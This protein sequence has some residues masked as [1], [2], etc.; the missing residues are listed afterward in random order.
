M[1]GQVDYGGTLRFAWTR[2]QERGRR[3]RSPLWEEERSDLKARRHVRIRE[4]GHMGHFPNGV[5]GS[6]DER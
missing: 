3:Q 5:W 6:R 1:A 2:N 4:N